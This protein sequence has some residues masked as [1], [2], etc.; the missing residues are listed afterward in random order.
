MSRLDAT[1][2]SLKRPTDALV[3]VQ[4]D[5]ETVMLEASDA[6][7]VSVKLNRVSTT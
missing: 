2:G 5:G 1:C 3:V 6:G 4:L 7:Q